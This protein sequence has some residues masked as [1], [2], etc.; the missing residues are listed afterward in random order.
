LLLCKYNNVA[1]GLHLFSHRRNFQED[2]YLVTYA[3]SLHRVLASL[4]LEI[5][6]DYFIKGK[7][8]HFKKY[9]ETHEKVTLEYSYFVHNACHFNLVVLCQK[10]RVVYRYT[11]IIFQLNM[12]HLRDFLTIPTCNPTYVHSL[13]TSEA[14]F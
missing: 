2:T 4:R 7:D 6:E 1:F 14:S 8:F 3:L 12:C 5:N 11:N 10:L 13:N 9:L